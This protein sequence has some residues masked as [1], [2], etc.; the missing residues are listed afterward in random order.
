MPP[1]VTFVCIGNRVR[2]TFAEFYL[3][4]RFSKRAEKPA[5]SAA[6][7]IPQA[8][9][10]Q[11]AE[12]RIPIPKPFFERP[13]SEQTRAALDEKGIRVP[14][15]WRSKELTPEMIEETDLLVTAL[16]VQKEELSNIYKDARDKI[17]SISDLSEREDY[18]FFEDFSVPILDENYWHYV[19]EDPEYVSEILRVWE[20]TLIKA[21]PNILRQ[22]GCA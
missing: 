10:D 19:E 4:D 21:I 16:G 17:F 1:H 6:G 18:L 12:A 2:S 14:D 8:F 9:K 22:L 3:A 7:F 15:G 13:M 5:V 20:E 11:L